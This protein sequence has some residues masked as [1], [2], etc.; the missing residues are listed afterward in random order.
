MK[1]GCR[2]LDVGSGSGYLTACFGRIIEKLGG[3]GVAVGI[4]HFPELVKWSTKNITK[5]DVNL[6]ESGRVVIIGLWHRHSRKHW[7][8]LII[9]FCRRRWSV[10]LSWIGS[11][12]CDSC[13][14]CRT[15]Y[16][17]NSKFNMIASSVR[18]LN[19]RP[20]SAFGSTQTRRKDDLSSWS[21]GRIPIPGAGASSPVPPH[22]RVLKS[23]YIFSM[24]KAPME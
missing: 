14:S 22:L 1:P 5:D 16:P 4:E 12:W 8:W 11:L 13:W 20:I 2:A 23:H 21:W 9:L 24:T 18:I 15:E 19:F 17:A 3:D 7:E 6:L 10:G